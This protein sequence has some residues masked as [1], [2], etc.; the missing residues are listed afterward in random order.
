LEK[1]NRI[2][3]R[4]IKAGS[5]Y[6]K[7]HAYNPV[8]WFEWGEEAW[9]KAQQE[10][11]LVLVSIGYSA[12]HWCHVME[13]ESFEDEAT[14]EIM[15]RF[16]VCIKVDREERPDVDQVYMDACQLITGRGGW[17]LNMFCL[18]DGRPV[19][20]GTYFP[21]ES[22]QQVLLQLQSLW[23][24]DPDKANE[25]AAQLVEGLHQMELV[26]A[27]KGKKFSREDIHTLYE[28]M[29]DQFDWKEGGANRS[30]KFPLPNQYEFLLN[31]HLSTGNREALEFCHLSLLKMA[32]GGIYDQIGGGFARYSTD[33]YWFAPHFEKM[34]YDNAQLIS[35]Y[36][37]AFGLSGAWVYEKVVRETL[38]FCFDELALPEGAFMSALDADSEGM[39]GRYYVWTDAELREALGEDYDFACRVWHCKPEGNWEHGYNIL[40]FRLAPAEWVKE[41]DMPADA[42]FAQLERCR[43]KLATARI[44]RPKP[45]LDDKVITS[46]NGIMLSALADAGFYLNEH[47]WTERAVRLADFILSACSNGEGLFRIWKDCRGHINAFLEDYAAVIQGLI[48]LSET[49]GQNR[50][51]FEA[52]RLLE[53]VE[54]YFCDEKRGIFFVSSSEDEPLIVRKTDLNDDVISSPN[55][56]IAQAMIKLGYIFTDAGRI[57]KGYRMLDAVRGQMEKFPGWYTCWANTA[58]MEA[59]GAVQLE[60]CGPQAGTT[61]DALR[62]QLP[63]SM[64]LAWSSDGSLVPVLETKDQA[65]E[66]IYLCRDQLCLEPVH[67]A[68]Q[69]LEVL[70]DLYG[71]ENQ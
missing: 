34:L 63:T 29:R 52:L 40:H 10:N 47:A 71:L 28:K 36:S 53:Y 44:N 19:H 39:E 13:H 30:P 65:S 32:N 23:Q 17:P 15:N 35:L 37:R 2:P 3:N 26:E 67:T 54:K 48:R 68:A 38:Q 21:R 60:V 59:F 69:A 5:P 70:E 4:L 31:Y 41:M 61:I 22:W 43:G 45:G 14:A 1:P 24:S 51:Y 56:I 66:T 27:P 25:Y 50:F 8:D 20:G 62:K 64:V 58:L 6:L 12:C 49:S 11:K 33:P 57:T 9:Q 7:Q 55:A 18:P 42:W 46:W 16:F